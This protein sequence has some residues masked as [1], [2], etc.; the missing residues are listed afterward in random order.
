MRKVVIIG[1]VAG[2]ASAA[3]RL[4]RLEEHCQIVVLEKSPY[5]SYAN[6]GLPY[7]ISGVIQK[8]EDLLLQTPESFKAR[9]GVEVRVRHEALSIDREKKSVLIRNLASGEEY[10]ESYDDLVLSPGALP[11]I[12]PGLVYD[13]SLVFTLR[14]IPDMETII[15]HLPENGGSVAIVG[16]GY[17]GVELAENLLARGCQV[18]LFEMLGQILPTM[19]AEMTRILEKDLLRQG[20]HL[21]LGSSIKSLQKTANGRLQALNEAG[22]AC[23][24]DFAVMAIGVRPDTHLAKSCGIR[25]GELGGILVDHEMRT[26]DPNIYAVGDAIEVTHLITGQ[27]TLMPLAGPANR[28]GRVAADVMAGFPSEFPGVIG[29]AAIK[30]F[31]YTAAHTGLNEKALKR[32]NMSYEK[33]YLHPSGHASYYPGSTLISFKLLFDP[34]NGRVL[35]AQAVGKKG[36]ER[37]IDVIAAYIMKNASIDDLVEAE[38]CYAPPLGS[39]KDAVNLAGFIAQNHMR[40]I[41]PL[42]HWDSWQPAWAADTTKPLILDVRSKTEWAEGHVPGAVHIPLD[43]LRKRIGELPQD[44]AIWAHCRVGLRSNIAIRILRQNGFDAYNISGGY[45]SFEALHGDGVKE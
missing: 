22:F 29:T 11:F 31:D 41:T 7:H 9:F 37:R 8:K 32:L 43:E 14:N 42:V 20:V 25:I 35:G 39:A 24:V 26:S 18:F 34:T 30:C 4:R 3:A 17:I 1:G 12:P 19:D 33:V 23:E 44:R 6:C 10:Q 36:I 5:V 2:G 28:Q 45:L 40:G 16:A 38:L 27:Q 13:E 21:V 15:S